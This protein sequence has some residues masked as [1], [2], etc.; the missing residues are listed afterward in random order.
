MKSRNVEVKLLQAP[1][2][3]FKIKRDLIYVEKWDI[4]SGYINQTNAGIVSD[5]YDSSDFSSYFKVITGKQP[6]LAVGYKSLQNMVFGP[7]DK[8]SSGGKMWKGSWFLPEFRLGTLISNEKHTEFINDNTDSSY[9]DFQ[10]VQTITLEF[11]NKLKV[12]VVDTD[13][14]G[15]RITDNL[16][17]WYKD[18]YLSLFRIPQLA[19]EQWLYITQAPVVYDENGIEVI[20]ITFERLNNLVKKSGQANE[21]FVNKGYS[22]GGKYSQGNYTYTSDNRS[23][24]NIDLKGLSFYPLNNIQIDL[25][26]NGIFGGCLFYGHPVRQTELDNIYDY[27][28]GESRL[29]IPANFMPCKENETDRSK[30]NISNM[31][32]ITECSTELQD[33]V[34]WANTGAYGLESWGAIIRA[35]EEDGSGNLSFNWQTFNMLPS[36]TF[37]DYY[38]DKWRPW[39]KAGTSEIKIFN[40]FYTSSLAKDNPTVSDVGVVTNAGVMFSSDD[41]FFKTNLKLALSNLQLI[42]LP[43]SKKHTVGSTVKSLPLIGGIA[44]MIGIGNISTGQRTTEDQHIEFCGLIEPRTVYNFDINRYTGGNNHSIPFPVFSGDNVNAKMFNTNFVKRGFRAYLYNIINN[45]NGNINT[46][47]LGQTKYARLVNEDGSVAWI[48]ND[49]SPLYLQIGNNSIINPVGMSDDI[50]GWEIDGIILQDFSKSDVRITCYRDDEPL[51]TGFYQT[52]GKYSDNILEW[53]TVIKTNGFD[54]E[55]LPE[56]EN[57]QWPESPVFKTFD[58]TDT[59][60][61]INV[62][63]IDYLYTADVY[64]SSVGTNGARLMYGWYG[65]ISITADNGGLPTSYGGFEISGRAKKTFDLKE[66]S[67]LGDN[68]DIENYESITFSISSYTNINSDYTFK[69]TATNSK[70]Q[71][72]TVPFNVSINSNYFN[73]VNNDMNNRYVILNILK[74]SGSYGNYEYDLKTNP[75]IVSTTSNLVITLGGPD[76][77]LVINKLEDIIRRTTSREQFNVFDGVE[78]KD[79][80]NLES[81][82]FVKPKNNYFNDRRLDTSLKLG[83]ITYSI[84]N[85]KL[86]TK[87]K[88]ITTVIGGTGGGDNPPPLNI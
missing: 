32:L 65:N 62:N 29:L 34:D 20:T 76:K 81:S 57:K 49:H 33:V 2:E 52:Q 27:R 36:G 43:L 72:I 17:E 80:I 78:I 51:W 25:I 5:V 42:T 44:N 88:D 86:I 40:K 23:L 35:K 39:V 61:D 46:Q 10:E 13:N 74:R 71:Q 11:S 16:T 85:I 75:T 83:S 37:I 19:G 45:G 63:F 77:N 24:I 4:K 28:V 1:N 14:V 84:N 31:T 69:L 53:Q 59:V 79:E 55:I 87:N 3:N 50:V 38:N 48:N 18:N 64:V 54:K 56:L 82:D 12:L 47:N 26:G 30:N 15:N 58:T 6:L 68:F 8:S 60:Y 67:G 9:I 7:D 73:Y 22:I 41:N 70:T 66:L 21:Q